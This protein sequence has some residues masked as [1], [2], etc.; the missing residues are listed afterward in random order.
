MQRLHEIWGR[1]LTG[2]FL[3]LRVQGPTLIAL[4]RVSGIKTLFTGWNRVP[5]ASLKGGPEPVPAPREAAAPT[6]K[7]TVGSSRRVVNDVY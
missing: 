5:V 2:T 3:S 4:V 6:P 1:C 7:R